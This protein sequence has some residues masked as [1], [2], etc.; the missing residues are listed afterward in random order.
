MKPITFCIL[1]GWGIS[2]KSLKN[3]VKHAKTPNFSY[4]EKNFPS[5][6]ILASGNEVGLPKGQVGNSEV[7]HMN[8]GCGRVIKQDLLRIDEAFQSSFLDENNLI[9]D[10][11]SKVKIN[12]GVAHIIALISD[13]GVHSKDEH[14]LKISQSLAKRKI[15]V[16]IHAFTDGRDTLPNSALDNLVS[17]NDKLPNGVKIASVMGRYYPM[18]RDNRWERTF[19]AWETLMLGKAK[20]CYKNVKLLIQEAY[21]RGETDEFISPSLVGEDKIKKFEGMNNGD[22]LLIGN[23]R[24][25]RVRQIISSLI[26]RDFEKFKREKFINFSARIG[27]VPYSD[28]IDKMLPS[29]FPKHKI[30]NSLGELVSNSGL[31]Q[32]RIA[33]TEKYPH[34]TFFFNGGNETAFQGEKR[35]LIPS[36]KVATYDLRPEMS[37]NEIKNS[38]I[39]NINSKQFDIIIANFANPD[40][41]GHSG[42]Y[43]ATI[44]A[45]EF[46]DKCIGSILNAV[47]NNNGILIL[48]SDHG[49]SEVMW[50]EKQSSKHTAHTYNP[51]PFILVN[52]EPNIKLRNGKLSDIAPTIL[53]LLK[54]N[55]PKEIEGKSLIIS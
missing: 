36:P 45:V 44:K 17:F 30:K 46:V 22:G 6:Q 53:D 28:K 8:I 52:G 7:G 25:D 20:H 49:N 18:D 26:D 32:L 24:S 21:S 12:K 48:T 50:D 37:A 47:N 5:T 11:A 39:E 33:E 42:N 23:F 15:E 19:I 14:I 16:L 9:D 4:L 3:A 10:F 2:E 27:M 35:I 54:I 13:G 51:V 34:V 1:D 40:M 43:E 55:K 41:V 29:L 38:I 31:R